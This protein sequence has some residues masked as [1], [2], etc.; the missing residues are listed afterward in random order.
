MLNSNTKLHS[1]PLSILFLSLLFICYSNAFAYQV[2]T[3]YDV[4]GGYPSTPVVGDVDGDGM[5]EIVFGVQSGTHGLLW[6]LRKYP[7][8]HT[9][10][11]GIY[12]LDGAVYSPALGDLDGDGTPEIVVYVWN[13]IIP[14]TVTALHSGGTIVWTCSAGTGDGYAQY[15]DNAP[16]LGDV[17]GDGIA[18]V[19]ITLGDR[20]SGDPCSLIVINGSDGSRLWAREL[21]SADY[22]MRKSVV[23]NLLDSYPG[24]EVIASCFSAPDSL[25]RLSIYQNDGTLV[26]SVDSAFDFGIAD[27]NGDGQPKII[28]TA[29]NLTKCYNRMGTLL[30]RY[31]TTG[32]YATISSPTIGD[33]DAD[34]S[35]EIVVA[36]GNGE[37]SMFESTGPPPVW[38]NTGYEELENPDLAGMDLGLGV[39][40]V[41]FQNDEEGIWVLNGATGEELSTPISS[42]A[43]LESSPVVADA[44][45]DNHSEVIFALN[46]SIYVVSDTTWGCARPVWNQMSYYPSQ[47]NDSLEFTGDYTP[48]NSG[49]SANVW[50]FQWSHCV[51]CLPCSVELIC[52]PCGGLTACYDQ[53]V[54]WQLQDPSGIS[55]D[56]DRTY[57]T[58]VITHA[59]STA[60]TV[61]IA[62]ESDSLNF[63]LI[64]SDSSNVIVTLSGFEFE[65]GD[66]VWVTIDSLYNEAGCLTI[67]EE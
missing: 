10:T 50:R 25:S 32:G 37:V 55:I 9:D 64:D 30:W 31:T 12:D 34:G 23:L 67:P 1:I 54:Q 4:G 28:T 18:D 35:P 43:E 40:N 66:L 6:I 17:N 38:T 46:H 33:F 19:A 57:F 8:D 51:A 56:F 36:T 13:G 7:D 42:G 22:G 44:D 3:S 20:S 29:R 24:N 53:I 5:P 2:E 39:I 45:N 52:G 65:S 58:V 11:V 63:E 62:G 49:D 48:W 47:I 61:H 16:S 27:V 15:S 21:V 14:G 26:W 41:L 59:D 60:D